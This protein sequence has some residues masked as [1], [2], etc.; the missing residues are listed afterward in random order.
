LIRVNSVKRPFLLWNPY[1]HRK[2]LDDGDIDR[3]NAKI[4]NTYREK[5]NIDAK[6]GSKE[7]V[8]KQ[9]HNLMNPSQN[10]NQLKSKRKKE[11]PPS[12][13]CNNS[14]KFSFS[15]KSDKLMEDKGEETISEEDRKKNMTSDIE[16]LKEIIE[17][18]SFREGNGSS[19]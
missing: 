3:K 1:I 15:N 14:Q 11:R 4:L 9:R 7:E 17:K 6:Q 19:N 16:D 2:Q 18:L 13:T 12:K 8:P 5:L 10:G